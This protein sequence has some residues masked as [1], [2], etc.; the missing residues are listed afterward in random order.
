MVTTFKYFIGV[1]GGGS[2]TRVIVAGP[3]MR[4]LA[5]AEGAPSA[6]GQGIEKAWRSILD[7][8]A[9]A[10]ANGKIAAPML[11]E[12][13]IG[14]GLS[15]ANNI[16]WKNEFY[17]RNPGFK[18]III[19]TDGF[20]TLLGAHLGSPGVIVA[21]GTGSVGMLLKKSKD[22]TIERQN[23]S[24]WG[25]PSGDEASGAW[26]G[27]RACALTEK[28]IDGRRL[29]SPL[30][31]AVQNFCG[32]T[33]DSFLAWLGEAQ[34][35]AFAKL[36]PLVFQNADTDQEALLLLTKAGLEIAE[37]VKTLDPN[38]ELPL[39]ICGRLGEALIPFL[40]NDLKIRNQKAKG[41][42][43]LGALYLVNQ[44]ITSAHQKK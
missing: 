24:G 9:Q 10:F 41:D 31:I 20:T 17:F 12:C 23:V 2:G 36:A 22:Q 43:T 1:D 40:P 5:H 14:L 7:T 27:Q 8:L 26:L 3:D 28:A 35:N 33:P 18:K 32:N 13:A 34:Q 44:S 15:G 37:M 21:V 30:T 6:L 25:F 39:S 42:S 4:P 38:S 19:D 29:H 16:L 11:S